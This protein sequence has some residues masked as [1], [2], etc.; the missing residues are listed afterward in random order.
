MADIAHFIGAL[1]PTLLVSRLML[2]VFKK[3]DGGY[4]RLVV[5]NGVSLLVACLL[6]GM[7]MADGGAFAAGAAF[8]TYAPAQAVWLAV[9]AWLYHRRQR[10]PPPSHPP[11]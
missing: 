1:V 8:A 6:G 11:A 4:T 9:D 10:M 2:L 5:A 3:W 7:G